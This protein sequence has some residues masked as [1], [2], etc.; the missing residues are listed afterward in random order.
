MIY[1]HH[2]ATSFPKPQPVAA[3]INRALFTKGSWKKHS[4]NL[5]LLTKENVETHRQMLEFVGLDYYH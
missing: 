5:S 4:H 3:A 2:G 1:L